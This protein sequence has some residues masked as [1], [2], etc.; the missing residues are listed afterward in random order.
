MERGL[1]ASDADRQHVVTALERHAT[2]GR[3]SLDEFAERVDRALAA[4]THAELDE[5]TVDL[6]AEATPPASTEPDHAKLT[7]AARQLMIAFMIAVA[8]LVLLGVV[9]AVAR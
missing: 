4:R 5:L 6:P 7:A 2:A 3:L 9:L 8:T 1:R